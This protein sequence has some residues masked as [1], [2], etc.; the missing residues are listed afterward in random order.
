MQVNDN[1]TA[2]YFAVLDKGNSIQKELIAKKAEQKKAEKKKQQE[3]LEET[4]TA[5][6]SEDEDTITITASSME[7]LVRK[8]NDEVYNS[9]SDQ[10]QTEAEK[11]IG[12][13]MDY[14]L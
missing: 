9:R 6:A 3:K 10:L 11:Q 8:V 14:R 1:G 5:K 7:E 4:R 12:Q 2:S 13:H